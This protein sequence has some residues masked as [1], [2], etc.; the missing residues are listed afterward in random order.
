MTKF[1]TIF[2]TELAGALLLALGYYFVV[3]IGLA[4]MR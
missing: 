1:M 4:G 3:T 2:L